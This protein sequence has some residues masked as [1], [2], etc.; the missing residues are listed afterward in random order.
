[1][2]TCYRELDETLKTRARDKIARLKEL[3]MLHMTSPADAFQFVRVK[4]N[5]GSMTRAKW[6]S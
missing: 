3:M 5:F 2:L 6:E 4:S 1:M